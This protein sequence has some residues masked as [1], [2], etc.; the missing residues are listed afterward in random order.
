MLPE[1]ARNIVSKMVNFNNIYKHATLSKASNL[2]MRNLG[3][4]DQ[5]LLVCLK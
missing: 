1:R 2:T 3:Y 5:Q 4:F